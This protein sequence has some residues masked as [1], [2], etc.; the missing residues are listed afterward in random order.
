MEKNQQNENDIVSELLSLAEKKGDLPIFSASLNNVRRISS[1]PESDAMELAQTVMKDSNLCAKLLRVANS[2]YYSRGLAKISSISRAVVL[3]GFDVIK[4]LCLTLKLIE[5]FQD[6]HP[7]I[8]MHKMVARS[9]LCAGL[10]RDIAIMSNIKN[11]EETYVSGLCHNIGEIAVGYFMPD[12][13]DEISDLYNRKEATSW[14][15]AQKEVLGLTLAQ[16]GQTI[17]KE[18]N[19][20]DK[21]IHSMAN[22]TPTQSDGP[23]RTPQQLNHAIVALSGQIID[24]IYLKDSRSKQSL[25]ELFSQ[26]EK[27]TGIKANR[28][29]QALASSF[30]RSCELIQSYGMNPSVLRPS[31]TESDDSL[32]DKFSRDFAFLATSQAEEPTNNPEGIIETTLNKASE[33]IDSHSIET[34]KVNQVI[35]SAKPESVTPQKGDPMAQLAYIQEITTLV[36]EGA[37]L[38]ALF[39]KILQG[40][41]EGVGFDRAALSLVSP[42]RKQYTTRISVGD[43]NEFL[44][45]N[46]RGSTDPRYDIFARIIEEG[47]DLLIEDI[48]DGT[49]NNLIPREILQGVKSQSIIIAGLKRGSKSLGLFYADNEISHEVITPLMRRGFLQFIAQSRLALQVV[50]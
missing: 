19:F 27:S 37:P 4:S 32:R 22:Y 41:K 44:T 21:V 23:A 35:S 30:T 34:V 28:L 3:L 46:L 9:Y 6:E 25:R 42:D 5:N 17:G 48:H 15:Q 10:V 20:S 39:S 7:T 49:W 43:D 31:V 50:N 12:K 45:Q 8:G 36:T 16:I 29:E 40:L 33:K 13:I 38:T 24:S 2:P 47:G 18:W 1:D 26:M 11:A 14:E